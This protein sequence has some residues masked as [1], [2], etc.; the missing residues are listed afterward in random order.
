MGRQEFVCP[1]HR[2]EQQCKA[3]V[4]YYYDNWDNTVFLDEM[5]NQYT[6]M[7]V[8]IYPSKTRNSLSYVQR[9]RIQSTTR[10]DELSYRVILKA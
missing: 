4:S 2:Q 5:C 7:I 10:N 3:C 6:H 9:A 1:F 8:L